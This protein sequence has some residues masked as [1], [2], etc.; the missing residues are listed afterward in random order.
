MNQLRV[1]HPYTSNIV[2]NATKQRHDL[3]I[4]WWP[5]EPAYPM[6][7]LSGGKH[8]LLVWSNQRT[9]SDSNLLWILEF[10]S[11]NRCPNDF[12]YHHR[13][14]GVHGATAELGHAEDGTLPVPTAQSRFHPQIHQPVLHV[15]VLSSTPPNVPSWPRSFHSV[16]GTSDFCCM[17]RTSA[18]CT[19]AFCSF[20][21]FWTL[22]AFLGGIS[23][24]SSM[25]LSATH[26]ELKPSFDITFSR[27]AHSTLS[28]FMVTKPFL[29][30]F[31]KCI[32]WN[33]S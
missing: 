23:Y 10:L 14:I 31:F 30:L 18:F 20:I 16:V 21:S 24:L 2:V 33:N 17:S 26:Q 7:L 3:R 1:A 5:A 12:D 4:G 22:P 32:E 27:K 13:I 19:S 15:V 28:S 29:S 25:S 9:H 11:W 8:R 6:A